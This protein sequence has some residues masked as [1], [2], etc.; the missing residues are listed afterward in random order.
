[1]AV[2]TAAVQIGR[3][4]LG[5]RDVRNFFFGQK[6]WPGGSALALQHGINYKQRDYAVSD[7]EGP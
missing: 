1:V 7:I 4:L 2:G 3:K 5:H 6:S